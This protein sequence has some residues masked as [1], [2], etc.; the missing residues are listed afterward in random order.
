[1]A[2]VVG[3]LLHAAVHRINLPRS[4]RAVYYPS[5]IRPCRWLCSAVV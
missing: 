2:A 1:M 3:Q 4:I 5:V